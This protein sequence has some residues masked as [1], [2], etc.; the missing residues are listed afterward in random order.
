MYQVLLGVKAPAPSKLTI[1]RR[2]RKTIN[3]DCIYD[4]SGASGS[5]LV[6]NLAG[7]GDKVK[8]E[9]LFYIRLSLGVKLAN[10]TYESAC[11]FVWAA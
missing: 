5:A 4:M 7:E 11:P 3:H 9:R 10:G 8:G 6:E 2:W 1:G